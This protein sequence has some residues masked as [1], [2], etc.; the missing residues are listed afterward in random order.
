LAHA[1]QHG[2]CLLTANHKDFDDL[3]MLIQAAGG[4]HA[5]ILIVRYDNDVGRDMKSK[6]VVIAVGKLERSGL[7]VANQTHILN[8]WR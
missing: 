8:H 5:G 2:L 4:K 6:D 7:E 1:I 3:H